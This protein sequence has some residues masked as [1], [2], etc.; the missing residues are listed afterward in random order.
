MLADPPSIRE[1]WEI[2]YFLKSYVIQGDTP[3]RVK[4]EYA[5]VTYF[6]LLPSFSSLPSF[7]TSFFS[8]LFFFL[9]SILSALFKHVGMDICSGN[10]YLAVAC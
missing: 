10:M 6:L 9:I 5:D 8:F 4:W 3:N 2:V 7:L 1:T